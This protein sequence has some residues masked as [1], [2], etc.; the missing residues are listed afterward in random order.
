MSNVVKLRTEKQRT[1]LEMISPKMAEEYLLANTHNRPLSEGTVEALADEMRAG[2][3]R[4]HHQ[5]IA[6]DTEGTLR[7]GQ[8]RL[9]AIV[10]SGKTLAIMVTRG[11]DPSVFDVID[12]HRPRKIGD[13]LQ[14]IHDLPQGRR[15]AAAATVLVSIERD[16]G[17]GKR[18]PIGLVLEVYK[19]HR[20]GLEFALTAVQT[21]PFSKAPMVAPLALAHATD[22]TKAATFAK[23]VRDGERLTKKDPAYS[24]RNFVINAAGMS[25]TLDR[26]VSST[27]A[28]RCLHA[29]FEGEAL[30][31]LKPNML[32]DS[33]TYAK[34]RRYFLRPFKNSL[35]QAKGT[36]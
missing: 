26:R 24:L 14:L 21:G 29:F 32:V 31:A 16:A 4:L 33:E 35:P 3:W 28:M 9:K 27:V 20:A 19:R 7:D 30:S 2:R 36:P 13:Q 18:H 5:G 22:A 8:H 23:Q 25:S 6:F 17:Y 1:D 12:A 15:I 34:A 10:L 11:I